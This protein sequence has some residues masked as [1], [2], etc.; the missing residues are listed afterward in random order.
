MTN[1]SIMGEGVKPLPKI[2]CN[3]ILT[4]DGT[5]LRSYHRHDYKEHTD[6]ITGELYMTD[7][8]TEYIRRSVNNVKAQDLD[9]FSTDPFESIRKAFVWKSYGKNGELFPNGVKTPLCMISDPH[10]DSIIETQVLV[11]HSIAGEWF[12]SEKQYRKLY[13]IFIDEYDY[14]DCEHRLL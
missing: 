12:R 3:A 1:L 4:P 6:K 7:G 9:V 2:V 10:L 14:I 13:N 8:G 11:M 5:Y